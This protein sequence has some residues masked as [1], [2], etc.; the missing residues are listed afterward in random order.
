M[1]RFIRGR[2]LT[3]WIFIILLALWEWFSRTGILSSLFFPAPTIVIRSIFQSIAAGQLTINLSATLI[4]VLLGFTMGGMVGILLG[5]AMGL[6]KNFQAVVDPFI[7]A[8]HPIP[9]IAILPLIMIILG[10]GEESKVAVIAVSAFFP[11]VINTVAG[12]SQIDQLYFDV[13]KNY[14]A[15]T[16]GIVKRVIVP[17]SLPL[18]LSGARIAL[19]TSLVVAIALELVAADRGLGA[20]IWLSWE[21]FRI[22]E[23]YV[24]LFTTALLGLGFNLLLLF[25]MKILIPWRSKERDS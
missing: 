6:W 20:M 11:M 25:V 22:E 10:I 23:L 1:K 12:I 8:A 4:R 19:N 2:W 7:S 9:K 3:A 16:V 14:G 5:I 24:S 18:I 17:G 21:T 13:T 15:G